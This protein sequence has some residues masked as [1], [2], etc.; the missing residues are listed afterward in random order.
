MK[1]G[2]YIYEFFTENVF[3]VIKVERLIYEGK[4]KYQTAKFIYN[5][6]LGKA[7]FLDNKIQS[8]QVDEFIFHESLV[9][10]ALLSH[11]APENVLIM[12]GGEGATLREVLKH[13]Q[14]KKAV[15]VD[16]DR[17]LV[18]LCKKF[19]P[20]W[21]SG[22]FS[23]K[24]TRF[25]SMDARHFIEKTRDKYH[26]IISDLTEPIDE[27]P[28]VFLFTREFFAMIFE[29]LEEDGI[30][31]IQAGSADTFYHEFFSSCVK[32]LESIFPLVK[33]YWTFIFSFGMPWGFVLASKKYDPL[34]IDEREVRQRLNERRVKKLRFYHPGIH[35]SYFSLPLYLLKGLKKGR[36][37]TDEKPFIWRL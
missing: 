16:I 36:I 29:K 28:S 3:K 4:T 22:A 33:P 27:G 30:F 24:K 8:A 32:T 20:E 31:V 11:P 7:L 13:S 26:V 19:L 23:D 9:H 18:E 5:G 17:E 21:S 15:M 34:K 14:V 12:G 10:P 37:L 6:L 35:R 25:F 2:T 1:E